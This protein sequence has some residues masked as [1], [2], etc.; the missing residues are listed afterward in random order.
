MPKTPHSNP[1]TPP[2]ALAKAIEGE[3]G[4]HSDRTINRNLN[5]KGTNAAGGGPENSG[6]VGD[7]GAGDDHATP[8]SNQHAS[9]L[10]KLWVLHCTGGVWIDSTTLVTDRFERWLMEPTAAL[11]GFFILGGP[12]YGNSAGGGGGTGGNA[13]G[14][15]F[16]T[17]SS[18]L[19]ASVPADDPVRGAGDT[20][21]S[22]VPPTPMVER[23]LQKALALGG[24]GG[25]GPVISAFYTASSTATPGED[26]VS[27]PAPTVP[28]TIETLVA[29]VLKEDEALQLKWTSEPEPKDIFQFDNKH[30]HG[31]CLLFPFYARAR[32]RVRVPDL[33]LLRTRVYV[34]A[35][36]RV[37]V[38]VC[39]CA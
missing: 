10:L 13:G 17:L 39:A 38:C 27:A 16:G 6:G 29:G 28:W 7:D 23:L 22:I 9:D 20:V 3:Q 4:A 35:C 2:A 32:V 34:C 18:A 5:K 24:S 21:K 36:A 37:C 1:I 19:L 30:T 26:E 14:G 25:R 8:T 11:G 15:D 33:S 12:R 31:Q